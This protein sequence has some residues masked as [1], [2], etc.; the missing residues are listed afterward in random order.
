MPDHAGSRP[1]LDG[2]S[3]HCVD[4]ERRQ[5]TLRPL[6]GETLRRQ[7]AL[8]ALGAALAA[9]A[10]PRAPAPAPTIALCPGLSIVTAVTQSE[11]DYESI[12]TI[13]SVTDTDVRIRYSVEQT[14]QDM[15][16]IEPHFVAY[17]LYRTVTRAD[18]ESAA[19]YLQIFSPDLPETIPGTTAI[20]TSARVLR[21]LKSRGEA[22]MALFVA[23]PG[24]LPL[25]RETHPNVYD[26]Q[27]SG[28][29]KR[30]GTPSLPVLVDGVRVELPTVQA[31]GEIFSD[32]V[33]FFFLDD[34]AN[35]IAL[36]FRLGIGATSEEALNVAREVAKLEG[37]RF[38][39]TADRDLL[40]VVKISSRCTGSDTLER[41]LADN[42]RA[43]V[44]DIYFS[45][46]K[47]TLRP[48]SEPT[49]NSIAAVLKKHPDWKLAI[50]G[51][52][53]NV[54]G[55]AY[56]LELSKR[57]AAAVKDALVKRYAIAATRLGTAGY[58]KTRPKDTND[59]LEGRARNRR[60][61]LVRLP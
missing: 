19:V 26:Y 42:G 59:T 11:G 24:K 2:G 14:V 18:L 12:K 49:L 61:E 22:D 46:N 50:E 21:D 4:R 58:G 48:E 1:T 20:G 9:F 39:K 8:A 10:A 40:Q 33:E 6:R 35:P 32:Q 7:P 25:D 52:T 45:F 37:K 23:I 30:V 41:E 38:V 36:K 29:L 16:D 57:R 51:H 60:V 53:D 17:S 56:N 43:D 55:D 13:E 34:P 5:C 27:S 47:D 31:T 28:H 54:A 44:Y 15:F 3:G